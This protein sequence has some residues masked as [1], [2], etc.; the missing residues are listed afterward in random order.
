MVA[1]SVCGSNKRRLMPETTLD[2]LRS[3]DGGFKPGLVAV[4]R[5]EPYVSIFRR[6]EDRGEGSKSDIVV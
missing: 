4:D 6:F 5:F 2:K 1:L 3:A